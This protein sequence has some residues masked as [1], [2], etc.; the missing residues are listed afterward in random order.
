MVSIRTVSMGQK[1][2]YATVLAL[3]LLSSAFEEV[4]NEEKPPPG[5]LPDD[6]KIYNQDI[7]MNISSCYNMYT[8]CPGE[9][10]ITPYSV[11]HSNIQMFCYQINIFLKCMLE[12]DDRYDVMQCLF[13][14]YKSEDQENF[15]V[16]LLSTAFRIYYFMC[17]RNYK[18]VFS[19][20]R[21]LCF[22]Q[23]YRDCVAIHNATKCLSQCPDEP[24]LS[25]AYPSSIS[26]SLQTV[27][28]VTASIALARMMAM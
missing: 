28:A 23:K 27:I 14:A 7:E 6:Y 18:I 1:L 3:V 19:W 15:E 16:Q 22:V 9:N 2:S 13:L 25:G 17:Q 8:K 4:D 10:L 20:D 11:T 24:D 5:I 21:P 12:V 26:S